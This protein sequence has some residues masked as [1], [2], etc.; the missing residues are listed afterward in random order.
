MC[1][2]QLP[3]RRSYWGTGSNG[4]FPAPEFGKRF[5]MNRLRF[6]EILM[7]LSFTPEK[8][9][10]ND[11]WFEVRRLIQMLNEKW[12]TVFAPGYKITVDESMFACMVVDPISPTE[13]PL[14]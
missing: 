2:Q 5:G 11:K 10:D 14:S 7:A 1:T 13:C 12:Q 8:V 3:E 4:L 9:N 6:E